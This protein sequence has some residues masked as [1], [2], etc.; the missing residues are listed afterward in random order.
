[1]SGPVIP[2]DQ[3]PEDAAVHTWDGANEQGYWT[4]YDKV[5][6]FW[7]IRSSHVPMPD[8]WDWR[9]PVM[10]PHASTHAVDLERLVS[11]RNRLHA[12][13][14]RVGTEWEA[15]AGELQRE[16][17]R[18]IDGQKAAPRGPDQPDLCDL[19]RVREEV[20]S[21]ADGIPFCQECWDGWQSE[22]AKQQPTKGEGE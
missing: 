2:A 12:M 14:C 18:L 1:M 20:R 5:G 9:V 10:R 13:A 15:E 3:W 22:E 8:G 16:V 4:V 7:T 21:D 6:G 17:Q 19:C 11:L